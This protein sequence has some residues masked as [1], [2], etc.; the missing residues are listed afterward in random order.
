ML[1]SSGLDLPGTE[2][3]TPLCS[4]LESHAPTKQTGQ[5]GFLDCPGLS[6]FFSCMSFLY[7]LL[8]PLTFAAYPERGRFKATMTGGI[9]AA[10]R[11]ARLEE[12]GA[13]PAAGGFECV[14]ARDASTVC[15]ECSLIRTPSLIS[16][17]DGV[18]DIKAGN[19]A[20]TSRVKGTSI[21]KLR[22][23]RSRETKATTDCTDRCPWMVLHSL[24]F[25]GCPARFLARCP[26]IRAG[27]HS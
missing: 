21:P 8:V 24:P 17:P 11:I 3:R 15:F 10:R 5:P 27:T 19:L 6:S 20:V 25:A 18:S 1:T 16:C 26:N 12:E 13:S 2:R 7:C 9:Q 23:P 14:C 22:D 4:A